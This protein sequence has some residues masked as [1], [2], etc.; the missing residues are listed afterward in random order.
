MLVPLQL[1]IFFR[2]LAVNLPMDNIKKNR[3]FWKPEKR[4]SKGAT[5]YHNAVVDAPYYVEILE[6]LIFSALPNIKENDIVVDYGA[7]TGVSAL[8]L[9]KHLKSPITLWL[10]DNSPAWLGKAYEVLGH[11]KFIK[12]LLLEKK[13]GYYSSLNETLGDKKVDYVISGNTFH[14]IDDIENIFS[15]IN[16]ALKDKGIFSFESGNIINKKSPEGALMVDSTVKRVHDIALNLIK[17]DPMFS[18]YKKGID[19]RIEKEKSQRKF[20]FPDPRPAE[21]YLDALKKTGFEYGE[22]EFKLFKVKYS[23]WLN[24]LRVKR[25]QAGIL[26]EIGGYNPT[27]KEANDRDKLITKAATQLFKDLEKNNSMADEKS[28]TI[29]VAYFT[30][31]KIEEPYAEKLIE[32]K[33]FAGKTALITGGSRGIG[34]ETA[35]ELAKQGS[36]IIINYNKDE[37][38]AKKVVSEVKSLNVECIAVQADVSNLN[39]VKGMFDEIRKKFDTIDILV[40]N[41]GIIIDKTLKNMNSDIWKKVIDVNLS[42]VFNVTKMAIP[43]IN[44]KGRIINVSSIS[45]LD[46]NFG[47]TNYAASKAAIIGFTKSLA[48]ELAKKKITVNTVAPGYIKTQMT[49]EMSTESKK[50]IEDRISLNELGDPKDIANSIVF[51]ASDKSRYITGEVLRVDGG[52]RT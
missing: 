44:F 17:N 30:S 13:N 42:S 34:K 29:E 24:F 41:A 4:I 20:V 40:N 9:L 25:L 18:D 36:N 33:L 46:G 50:R 47:Q 23:D 43:L 19:E 1:S 38:G 15:G 8:Y 51:F 31:Q 5:A 14:L 35:I 45:G 12:C 6:E 52:L 16:L 28:F 26:P 21:F 27:P 11:R 48:K 37:I 22:P 39:E 49:S 3:E 2:K 10:V 7:G 32:I